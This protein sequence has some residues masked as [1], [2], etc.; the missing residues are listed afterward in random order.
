M[1]I[2]CCC[3]VRPARPRPRPRPGPA[4]T[5]MYVV[6]TGWAFGSRVATIKILV[7]GCLSPETCL[8]AGCDVVNIPLT[9]LAANSCQLPISWLVKY[10]QECDNREGFGS[11]LYLCKAFA[12]SR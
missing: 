12:L 1:N 6:D 2:D 4:R 8:G 5:K 9:P 11:Q 10:L 3:V 7:G